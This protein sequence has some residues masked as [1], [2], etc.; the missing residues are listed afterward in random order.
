MVNRPTSTTSSTCV[1]I[2]NILII[3]YHYKLNVPKYVKQKSLAVIMKLIVYLNDETKKKLFVN[4]I[5]K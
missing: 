5:G 3:N 4:M 1:G 2:S